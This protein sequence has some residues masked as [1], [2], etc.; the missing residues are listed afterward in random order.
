MKRL[1]TKAEPTLDQIDKWS[2]DAMIESLLSVRGKPMTKV[3]YTRNEW[4]T[5]RTSEVHSERVKFFQP[6]NISESD[7]K[8]CLGRLKKI[9]EGA[10]KLHSFRV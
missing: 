10:F 9:L 2:P 6:I 1:S 3:K 5:L 7:I 8:C 4:S